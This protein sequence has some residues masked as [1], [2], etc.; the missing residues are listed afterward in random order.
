MFAVSVVVLMAFG[1]ATDT[2]AR[3][4]KTACL[5]CLMY[6]E[7]DDIAGAYFYTEGEPLPA[8][9]QNRL[10]LF[11][12]IFIFGPMILATILAAIARFALRN[13][14]RKLRKRRTGRYY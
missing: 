10:L 7:G 13:K 9:N 8:I 4:R 5:A 12:A 14:P 1:T 6:A 3:P 2:Q 11:L